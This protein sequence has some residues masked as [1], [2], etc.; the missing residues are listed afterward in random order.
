VTQSIVIHGPQG[1]GKSVNAQRLRRKFGLLVVI[2][3]DDH[4][5]Q[6]RHIAPEGALVLT[7]DEATAR[8]LPGLRV[9]GFKEA[10][11]EAGFL[12]SPKG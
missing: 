11:R 10:M 6:R 9:M 7:N 8:A 5:E 1:C 12:R 3:L 2:E 4:P